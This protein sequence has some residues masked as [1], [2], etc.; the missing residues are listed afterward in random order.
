MNTIKT[1]FAQPLLK[2]MV[3]DSRT[4]IIYFPSYKNPKFSCH[5]DSPVAIACATILR[6]GYAVEEIELECS[7][8]Q[9]FINVKFGNKLI[10]KIICAFQN[11]DISVK[12]QIDNLKSV[13]SSDL[14]DKTT[15]FIVNN[16]YFK[17][18][19]QYSFY[20][21]DMGLQIGNIPKKV[22]DSNLEKYGIHIEEYDNDKSIVCA[23]ED[24]LTKTN[25][26][27]FFT[28]TTP[29]IMRFSKRGYSKFNNS[30]VEEQEN[31]R[32][33]GKF[34]EPISY[35]L[36][37]KALKDIV[38]TSTNPVRAVSNSRDLNLE[39]VIN[40][41]YEDF[42][43]TIIKNC[44]DYKKA[45]VLDKL[46]IARDAGQAKNLYSFSSDDNIENLKQLFF[47]NDEKSKSSCIFSK[48]TCLG[49][50]QHSTTTLCFIYEIMTNENVG[51]ELLNKYGFKE[52]NI[53]DLFPDSNNI[54]SLKDIK[55]NIIQRLKKSGI[56]KEEFILYLEAMEVPFEWR[57][58]NSSEKMID[59]INVSNNISQQDKSDIWINKNKDSVNYLINRYNHINA[60]AIFKMQEEKSI[61]LSMKSIK[62]PD[63]SAS[64]NTSVQE[65][66]T[67]NEVFPYINLCL[68]T[69][70]YL[71]NVDKKRLKGKYYFNDKIIKEPK[72]LSK[73][74]E[75]K[76]FPSVYQVGAFSPENIKEFFKVDSISE[77][78]E[79][80]FF[81]LM[82]WS[83]TDVIIK[84]T[85]TKLLNQSK[86]PNEISSE[87]IIKENL[88]PFSKFKEIMINAN[89]TLH[90]KEEQD[91]YKSMF[92]VNLLLHN[93]DKKFILLDPILNDS[94]NFSKLT[95]ES[96]DNS[97]KKCFNKDNFRKIVLFSF[98]QKVGKNNF[99]QNFIEKEGELILKD[100]CNNLC[101][102][103]TNN[104]STPY[105]IDALKRSKTKIEIENE[106]ELQVLMSNLFEPLF[107][108]E[109]YF[110]DQDNNKEVPNCSYKSIYSKFMS[111]E[112]NLKSRK[113]EIE[114]NF[115]KLVF[116]HKI[117][118]LE[119]TKLKII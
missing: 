40:T 25:L 14:E 47:Y 111:I 77:P 91:I 29:M 103:Y 57:S 76:L 7:D 39:K 32:D 62:S 114:E 98:I 56:V 33:Y 28:I 85:K 58:F 30:T 113:T 89:R 116:S 118:K 90:T 68:S 36:P 78:N 117:K 10:Q 86:K 81:N 31:L 9:D 67:I 43:K 42:L 105:K 45:D 109:D 70:D 79:N 88:D 82:S 115:E 54:R 1:I 63:F 13:Y 46:S 19:E 107:N 5:I 37:L 38:L 17:S 44:I 27:H 51:Y 6:Q 35:T 3:L 2:T 75:D 71:S 34:S 41:K 53:C 24:K 15:Y 97:S 66:L 61:L 60:E 59:A 4:N 100:I 106:K 20:L 104:E 11:P 96:I 80:A 26:N 23:E 52:E 8:K 95:S 84:Q 73:H 94:Y 99:N 83:L 112:E 102:Y 18:K 49:N 92:S 48:S 64:V 87:E 55:K 21:R 110:T 69:Q 72:V 16:N 50:G 12:E 22:R 74:T 65:P 101:E 119:P 108:R 93:I